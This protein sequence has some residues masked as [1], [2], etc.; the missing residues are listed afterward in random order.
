M[1]TRDKKTMCEFR[2]FTSPVRFYRDVDDQ[3]CNATT[4]LFGHI[5]RPNPP[6]TA[7]Y[8][9]N[10]CDEVVRAIH[11]HK[12]RV[13][14]NYYPC[15]KCR[16]VLCSVCYRTYRLCRDCIQIPIC[17]QCGGVRPN[18]RTCTCPISF[19]LCLECCVGGRG[20]VCEGCKFN[21]KR[22]RNLIS[23]WKRMWRWVDGK[24]GEISMELIRGYTVGSQ[25]PGNPFEWAVCVPSW[26]DMPMLSFNA[27]RPDKRW[28]KENGSYEPKWCK[29]HS[30]NR[31]EF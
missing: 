10:G 21:R 20:Y 30:M 5:V 1:T 7:V 22:Y 16:A 4:N 13:S 8:D 23:F 18:V 11:D 12:S 6:Y 26:V 19:P 14:R 3:P 25:T 27:C 29:G 31:F 15:D 17:I 2:R 28:W 9:C 24:L